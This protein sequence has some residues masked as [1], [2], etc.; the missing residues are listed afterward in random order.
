MSGIPQLFGMGDY[1][2]LTDGA[3]ISW[4]LG[5]SSP[6]SLAN[7]AKVKLG[8]N[9]TLTITNAKPG[10]VL[11][12]LVVQDGTGSRT[13]TI[14]NGLVAGTLSTTASAIDQ[15]DI[16]WSP[17]DGKFYATVIGKAYA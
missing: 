10:Q 13:L 14:T 9:R 3:T 5:A 6:D 12:L 2:A 16:V 11:R 8:G 4:N 17:A 1:L 7:F 15:L